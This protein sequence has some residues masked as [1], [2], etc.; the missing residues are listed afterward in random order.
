MNLWRVLRRLVPGQGHKDEY[1][2]P[3][4][5]SSAHHDNNHSRPRG[6]RRPPYSG[7]LRWF[8]LRRLA[9]LSLGDNFAAD[10]SNE[11]ADEP[12]F[13]DDSMYRTSP[14]EE[15]ATSPVDTPFSTFIP[16]PL[17]G[18]QGDFD[19][20]LITDTADGD[21]EFIDSLLAFPANDGDIPAKVL[22]PGLSSGKLY[23]FSPSTPML[24]SFDSP[25]TTS[26]SLSPSIPTTTNSRPVIPPAPRRRSRT[27]PNATGTLKNI[28]P[29]AL[30]PLDAP[31]QRR[32]YRTA[33]AT[34]RKKVPVRFKRSHR[35]AFGD[36]DEDEDEA[37]LSPTLS[38]LELIEAKRRQN[39]LAARK[40]RKRKLEHTQMLEGMV[41]ELKSETRLHVPRLRRTDDFCWY[42]ATE[43][44][45]NTMQMRRT[46]R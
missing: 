45:N 12:L 26:A 36:E 3:P 8:T 35:A 13:D 7:Y 2:L 25:L 16:T 43:Y 17:M 31:T 20:P 40:S 46:V 23:T 29:G 15:L 28:S 38:D 44:Y 5:S 34:S 19:E 32:N 24:D 42:E 39:T 22:P 33:S 6:R 14:Q 11:Y 21:N 37:E 4:E 9:M 18:M 30:I 10:F 1:E 41:E 27:V